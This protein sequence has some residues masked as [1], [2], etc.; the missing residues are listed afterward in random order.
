MTPSCLSC[1]CDME[2]A[3]VKKTSKSYKAKKWLCPIC[4]YSE[5]E[6]GQ[7]GVDSALIRETAQ[8][9]KPITELVDNQPEI[10]L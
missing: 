3:G 4:G 9:E 10:D 2:P 8:Q 7:S 5:L 6:F 1:G